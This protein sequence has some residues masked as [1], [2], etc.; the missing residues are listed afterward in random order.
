MIFKLSNPLVSHNQ[1]ED[2][3]ENCACAK[4]IIVDVNSRKKNKIEN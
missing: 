1:I 3:K 4:I 2:E